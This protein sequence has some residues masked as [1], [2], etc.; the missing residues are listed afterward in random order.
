MFL[1]SRLRGRRPPGFG[2]ATALLPRLL[3]AGNRLL[4]A[5]AGAS[6]GLRAL[7]ADREALA[8]AQA[9]PAT[10]LHL[11]ADVLLDVAAQVAL[12]LQVRIHVRPDGVDL[13]VGEV[14]LP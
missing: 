14:A 6:V 8:V 7:A 5:L 3:L 13:F 2:L 4:G 12:D 9:L 1:R 10:D 11:P